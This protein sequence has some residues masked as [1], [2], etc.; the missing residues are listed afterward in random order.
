VG[1]ENSLCTRIRLRGLQRLAEHVARKQ[2]PG[3][4]VECGVYRGGSAVVIGERLL[5]Q[6]RE[7]WLFDVFSGMPEPG[8]NDQQ[9]AWNDLG[10]FASSEALVRQTLSAGAVDLHRV[11]I[12]TGRYENTLIDFSPSPVAF[13]HLDCDWYASVRLCLEAFY[14]S[15]VPGGVVVVDDYGHWAGCKKAVDEFVNRRSIGV[16]LTP[17]DYTGHYFFKPE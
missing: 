7:M 1:D 6:Q 4:V 11:H 10:K 8:E 12:V 17:I 15:V 14:D 3:D 9:E 16:R 13:L 2:I 5:R